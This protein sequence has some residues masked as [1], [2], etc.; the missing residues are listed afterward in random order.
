MAVHGPAHGDAQTTLPHGS[1]VG[2]VE[3]N[4][5]T[6]DATDTRLLAATRSEPATSGIRITQP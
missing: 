6:I 3:P 1:S 2:A 5:A 4:R